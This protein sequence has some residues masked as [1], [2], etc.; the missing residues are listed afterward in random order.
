MLLVLIL[1]LGLMVV[2]QG[3]DPG[4]V[5]SVL[6]VALMGVVAAAAGDWRHVH[7][8]GGCWPGASATLA[9]TL[10]AAVVAALPWQHRTQYFAVEA[11]I[12]LACG[13]VGYLMGRHRHA[14]PPIAESDR[15]RRLV[16][17]LTL[18]REQAQR[19]SSLVDAIERRYAAN[20]DQIAGARAADSRGVPQG[21]RGHARSAGQLRRCGRRGAQTAGVQPRRS[22]AR[23]H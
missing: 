6:V 12:I 14:A 17:E 2:A 9:L 8:S 18:A 20:V 7:G 1:A 3:L 22:L 5:E 10:A 21:D 19:T 16:H 13:W 4:P 11:V 23:A 15:V